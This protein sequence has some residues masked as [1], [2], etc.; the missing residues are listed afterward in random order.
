MAAN[1]FDQFD[2]AQTANP[3]DQFDAA[4]MQVG[5]GAAAIPGQRSISQAEA[6]LTKMEM[7]RG[8]IETPFAVGANLLSGPVTYMAGALGPEAQQAVASGIQ[9]QPR[10][11]M[12]QQALEG[13]ASAANAAKIPPYMPVVGAPGAITNSGRAVGDVVRAGGSAALEAAQPVV[14]ALNTARTNTANALVGGVANVTAPLSGKTGEVMKEAY[15]AGKTGNESFAANMRGKVAPDEVLTDIKQGISNMQSANS[16]AYATAKT[17]WSADKTPLNFTAIDDK[18]ASVKDSLMQGGK[19][20]IGSAEQGIVH[21]LEAVIDEWRSDPK[22]R[23]ALDLDALKQRIDAIYPESPKHTQAQRAITTLRNTVKDEIVKQAPDYADA[24]KAYDEQLTIIRDI[25]K[26]LGTGDK[27]AKETAINKAMSLLKTSPSAKFRQNLLQELEQQ[28]GV[29]IM[30]SLAGQ[31]L[32]TWIPSS[33]IGKAVMGGGFTAAT[34]AHNP[35]YAAVLPFTSPRLMG[36]AFYGA[37]KLAGAGGRAAGGV[38]NMLT[39]QMMPS[40][41]NLTPAQA[42]QLNM[43]LQQSSQQNQ[44]SLRK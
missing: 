33:G 13:I 38:R 11:R 27:V 41:S 20:K 3:F 30:P 23:T 15:K 7:L 8:A 26:A 36:E 9:Y 34:L 1:P 2:T 37:G 44:N 31:D 35:A 29:D 12:A 43:M 19:S 22:A 21:E 4:P 16:E 40:V 42:Q 6:P 28:G 32:S 25:N 24:M 5:T 14:N 10:T 18:L 39:N 17:G